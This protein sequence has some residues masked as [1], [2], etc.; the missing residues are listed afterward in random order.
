MTGEHESRPFDYDAELRR[1]HQRLQAAAAV[2][3]DDHVL[4]IGCGTG[5][6]TREAAS[7]AVRGSAV[8]VDISA[9]RLATARRLSKLDGLRNIHFEQAD[10][11]T[12]P[13]QADL[14]SVAVGR[15]GTMFF[16]D[17]QTAF[18]NIARALRPGARFVQLVWQDSKHQDWYAVFRQTLATGRTLPGRGG[19]FSLADPATAEHLLTTAGFTNIQ[20][21]DTR[22]PVYWGPTPEAA[23]AAAH[24][25]GMTQDLLA[26]L[27]PP[28][29]DEALQHLHASVAAHHTPDG[30]WFN[31][32]AWLITAHRR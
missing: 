21:T 4:D 2:G 12:H 1:Y 29:R 30:V 13:F 27:T 26:D 3:P 28:Q 5:L 9:E 17:P 25:L 7:A 15:F 6:T 24:S 20:I 18:T 23:L 10:A 11:Q 22:E 8:G 31:S 19:A 16:S 14:F 32:R